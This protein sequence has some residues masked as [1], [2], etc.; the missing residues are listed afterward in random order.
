[1]AKTITRTP[2][3]IIIYPVIADACS[4]N[5]TVLIWIRSRGQIEITSLG[6]CVY[7]LFSSRPKLGLSGAHQVSKAYIS[8]LL[9]W[10]PNHV[11]RGDQDPHEYLAP[12]LALVTKIHY[13]QFRNEMDPRHSLPTDAEQNQFF[14]RWCLN[15]LNK[16]R[17]AFKNLR[18]SG[19]GRHP[20]QTPGLLETALSDLE[21]ILSEVEEAE[22]Y[23]NNQK[24][25]ELL[26]AQLKEARK[27]T[28]TAS[29][30]ARLTQLAF[31]FIPLSFVTSV[32]GMNIKQFNNGNVSLSA[33]FATAA[34]M[35][36]LTLFPFLGL[37]DGE[38]IVASIKLFRNSPLNGLW[39]L[40]F[41]MS[42]FRKTNRAFCEERMFY[43]LS[44]GH[45]QNWRRD[46]D[47][48][49]EDFWL[50]KFG[51]NTPGRWQRFW[52]GRVIRI[53]TFIETEI[54]RPGWK[55]KKRL[56]DDLLGGFK[57]WRLEK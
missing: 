14:A 51:W 28:E 20:R 48:E 31:F 26:N 55:D 40:A 56:L 41:T 15:S 25:N 46:P 50:R 42:H 53:T 10:T 29:S 35:T 12:L 36:F 9:A 17:N 44:S 30:V 33:F 47:L 1:M 8:S 18:R 11:S 22:S 16:M 19:I 45:R 39:F 38:I 23:F 6:R 4:K 52:V 43:Y 57:W 27:S 21:S 5:K 24:R 49:D 34:I 13:Y 32:F 37:I 3:V 7:P 54:K 2:P